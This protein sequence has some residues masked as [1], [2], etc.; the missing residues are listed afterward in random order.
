ML[1]RYF[2]KSM[3]D[4]Y[5]DGRKENEKKKMANAKWHVFV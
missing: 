1:E 5:S 2:L 4:K 3:L